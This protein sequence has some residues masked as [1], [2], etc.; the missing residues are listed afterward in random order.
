[1]SATPIDYGAYSTVLFMD[2]MVALEGKSLT[3]QPWHEIDAT[4]PILVLVVPQVSKEIDKRKRDGR[5]GQRARAFNRLIVPAAES[6]APVRIVDGP[7]MVDLAIAACERISWDALDDLDPEEP[8]DRVVAQVLHARGVS[9]ARKLLFSQ[10]TNPIAMASRH[11]IKVLKMPEHWLLEPEPSPHEKELS[12]LKARVRELEA[13]EPELSA[14]VACGIDRPLQ[15][16]QVKALTAAEQERLR[17]E[18]IARNP[19]GVQETSP[20]MPAINRDYSYSGRYKRYRDVIV[21]RHAATLHKRIETH[22]SQIPFSVRIENG[23]HIQ[24]ENLVV[25]IAAIGGTVHDRFVCYPLFEPI[26]PQVPFVGVEVMHIE[27]RQ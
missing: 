2:S 22:Y 3:V 27:F 12:R 17:N 9:P 11:G 4:G 8:D 10:D 23:G 5:L 14:S 20:W 25:A 26:A 7:P 24:A 18:I 21:P 15:L 6:G 13:D 1:M 19:K 16:Y